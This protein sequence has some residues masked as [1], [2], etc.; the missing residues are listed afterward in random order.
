MYVPIEF[1]KNLRSA[2]KIILLLEV[3]S[4]IM[5]FLYINQLPIINDLISDQSSSQSI[6]SNI[7]WTAQTYDE[8]RDPMLYKFLLK[9]PSTSEA[10]RDVTSWQGNNSWTWSTSSDDIGKNQ[11]KVQVRDEKHAGPD[12]YDVEKTASFIITEP[13]LVVRDLRPSRTSPQAAGSEITWTADA[14]DPAGRKIYYKFSILGPPTNGR[15]ISMTDWITKSS[16]TWKTKPSDAGD[17]QVYVEIKD[18]NDLEPEADKVTSFTLANAPPEQ[19]SLKPNQDGPQVYGTVIIWKVA[20]S[21][22]N[23]DMIYYRFLLSDLST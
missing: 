2:L 6:N 10:W 13:S 15:K 7:R 19:P 22:P 5:S 3:G 18:D 12:G 9:G 21:D 4:L 23:G 16:W 11:I 20:C 8:D 1:A 17:Y 14:Y